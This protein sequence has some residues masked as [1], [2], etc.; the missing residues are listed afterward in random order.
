MCR[1]Y[2]SWRAL[3]NCEV[4]MGK[5]VCTKELNHPKFNEKIEHRQ[6]QRR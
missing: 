6:R 5:N 4:L 1:Y 3:C 2:F